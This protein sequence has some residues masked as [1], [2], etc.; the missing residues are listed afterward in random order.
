MNIPPAILAAFPPSRE[1]LL[2]ATR[3]H[4]DDKM[5]NEI[6]S[7]DYGCGGDDHF[8][9]LRLIRDT[10]IVAIP[11]KWHPGEVLELIRWSNPEDPNHKP[12]STGQRGHQ[13]RVF[14]CAALLRAADDTSIDAE[15]ATLAQCLASAL[16]LG[17]EIL[18]ASASFLNWHIPRMTGNERWL[19][20][21]GLLVVASRFRGSRITDRNL[22]DAATWVLAEESDVRKPFNLSDPPPA[23][24]GITYGFWAPLAAE[25][26][27]RANA[28]E[29][30]EVREN[31]ELIGMSL[32]DG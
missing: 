11:M 18:E 9:A 8:A 7:A 21:F 5:L 25:L 29:V 13:M 19:F 28:I 26:T 20:A 32:L 31:I 12:G 22:G 16:V 1:R 4:V 2:D 30:R 14:A 3:R 15:E 24:F 27:S 23:A 10:G 17:G 6:A